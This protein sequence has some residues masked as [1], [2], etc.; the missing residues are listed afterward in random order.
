[1]RPSEKMREPD[2]CIVEG[3]AN[4]VVYGLSSSIYTENIKNAFKAIEKIDAGITYINAPTIG[5]E[6]RGHNRIC[7]LNSIVWNDG[8]LSL[9]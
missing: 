9:G 4:S 2:W 1:M 8:A 5:A 6:I 7:G 3:G